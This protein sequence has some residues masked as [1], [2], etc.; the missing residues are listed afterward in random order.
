[1]ACRA[2]IEIF[3]PSHHPS[4]TSVPLD[5]EGGLASG[6][7][8]FEGVDDVIPLGLQGPVFM[9]GSCYM[10]QYQRS[11]LSSI[12]YAV[13]RQLYKAPRVRRPSLWRRPVH[14]VLHRLKKGTPFGNS[15][16]RATDAGGVVASVIFF[17][18]A[19]KHISPGYPLGGNSED[20][21]R[22]LTHE[23]R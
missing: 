3:V 12:G 1:M 11:V 4:V 2:W 5:P 8:S 23:S 18:L 9:R 6:Q 19:P 10:G 20:R 15:R 16:A 13:D 21:N 17:L 14:D 22:D 7:G